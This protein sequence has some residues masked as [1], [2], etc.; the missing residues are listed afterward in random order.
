MRGCETA[1]GRRVSF[2]RF[3]FCILLK[4]ID[5]NIHRHPE[6]KTLCGFCFRDV[7]FFEAFTFLYVMKGYI[8]LSDCLRNEIP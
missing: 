8:T 5:Y 4:D 3:T 2:G 1:P 7:S 6:N